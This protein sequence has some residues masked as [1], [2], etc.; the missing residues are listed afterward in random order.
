MITMPCVGVAMGLFFFFGGTPIFIGS[1]Y[2]SPS[3]FRSF[4]SFP[5]KRGN[6]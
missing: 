4:R 6:K 5:A 3:G 2:N 1:H